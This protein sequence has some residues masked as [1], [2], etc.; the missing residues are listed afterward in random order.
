MR[1][2][3]AVQATGNGHISRA[4]ELLPYLKQYGKV[5]VF[6]SGNNSSLLNLKPAFT[7][8]GLSLYYSKKGGLDYWKMFKELQVKR[9]YNEAKQLPVEKYDVILNDFESI[10]AL[11][12]HMKKIPFLHV[13]H[14]ASFAS[15]KAP[16]PRFK[17][18]VGEL[19]LKKYCSSKNN[20]GFHF[21]SYDDFIAEPIIK[22]V[23]I[24][25]KPVNNGHVT[26]YLPQYSDAAIAGVLKNIKRK[27]FH[28]FSKS[29]QHIVSIDNIEFYPV[30]NQLFNE[31]FINCEGII[32]GAGFETPAEAL[33][34]NKK[35]MC[36]PIAGQYEQLCNAA[37]LKDFNVTVLKSLLDKKFEESFYSWLHTVGQ[38]PLILSFTT[39]NIVSR[40]IQKAAALRST[41]H[42]YYLNDLLYKN[43]D[44]G[45]RSIY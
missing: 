45:L 22:D 40:F 14:Q 26:V 16:R 8:K 2:F 15:L 30:N 28:V 17:N 3:Y 19:V 42:Q 31:S 44:E 32:T 7:S 41:A 25:A 6:L 21:K 29:K 35:L 34:M 37:A 18:P 11:A 23:I 33:Y 9:I 4:I 20:F 1:I 38:K 12:C 36:I 13:G 5:D 10:T 43:T 24:N 27:K 39:E